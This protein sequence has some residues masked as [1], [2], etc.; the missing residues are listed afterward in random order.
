MAES[1]LVAFKIGVESSNSEVIKNI[2]KPTTLWRLPDK[3]VCD[4]IQIYFSVLIL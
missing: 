4:A 3:T 2:R 1:G